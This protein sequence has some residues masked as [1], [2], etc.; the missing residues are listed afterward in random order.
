M[1]KWI[2]QKV[3]DRSTV[4]A[5]PFTKKSDAEAA[6]IA[7][8]APDLNPSEKFISFKKAFKKILPIEKSSLH[9]ERQ[10][11]RSSFITKI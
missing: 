3:E 5:K 7:M 6:M 4:S 1:V 10:Q 8:I 2:I 11:S 9:E